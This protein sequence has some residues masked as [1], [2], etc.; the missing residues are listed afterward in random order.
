[1]SSALTLG[2]YG[3][4]SVMQAFGVHQG[5]TAANKAHEYNAQVYE[6]NAIVARQNAGISEQKAEQTRAKGDYDLARFRERGEQLKGSQRASFGASGVV[7]DE[8]STED[9]VL[10]TAEQL[11]LDAM[12][13]EYNTEVAAFDHEMNARAL[14]WDA[15]NMTAQ[16]GLER[17]QKRSSFMPVM[18][19]LLG[20]VGGLQGRWFGSGTKSKSSLRQPKTRSKAEIYRGMRQTGGINPFGNYGG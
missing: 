7:V 13:M 11:E 12:T 6:N 17:S 8:G 14:E 9:V 15:R 19:S 5:I 3:A 4:G 10:D 16:A 2:A 18:S 20:S 1:M